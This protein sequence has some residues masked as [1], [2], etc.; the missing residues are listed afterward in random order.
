MSDGEKIEAANELLDK[1]EALELDD[2]ELEEVGGGRLIGPRSAV[3]PAKRPLKELLIKL[4]GKGF[5]N[6]DPSVV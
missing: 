4:G 6:I 5:R 1:L 2:S 3:P